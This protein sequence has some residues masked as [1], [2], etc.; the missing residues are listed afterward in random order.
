MSQQS[1]K[2]RAVVDDT[3]KRGDKPTWNSLPWSFAVLTL[4]FLN[5]LSQKS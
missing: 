2:F 1:R 4:L 5:V 3:A